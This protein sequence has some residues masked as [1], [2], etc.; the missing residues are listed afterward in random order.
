MISDNGFFKRMMLSAL[1]KVMVSD[2]IK[3]QTNQ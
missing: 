1:K 2:N 3:G